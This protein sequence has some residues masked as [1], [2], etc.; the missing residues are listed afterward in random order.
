[1][2]NLSEEVETKAVLD[3]ACPTS[4]L[5]RIAL[6]HIRLYE[7]TELS[8]LVE[9]AARGEGLCRHVVG[10]LPHFFMFSRVD[11]AS[12]IRNRNSRLSDV[13]GYATR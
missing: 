5:G 7:A 13:S 11:H 10:V 12:D 6:G 9:P 4:P 2:T 3:S 1:M 8:F